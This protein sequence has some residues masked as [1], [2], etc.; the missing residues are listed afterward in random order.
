MPR[1]RDIPAPTFFL[2]FLLYAKK[3]RNQLVKALA[4]L[5]GARAVEPPVIPCYL[6]V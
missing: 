4:D 2:E 6:R 5:A 3:L 1:C